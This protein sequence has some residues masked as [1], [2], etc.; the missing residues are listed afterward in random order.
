MG[1]SCRNFTSAFLLA[2]AFVARATADEKADRIDRMYVADVSYGDTLKVSDSRTSTKFMILHLR[3][4]DAPD[5]G[6]SF[7]RESKD[8]LQKL[9]NHKEVDVHWMARD[10][11][12][13]LLADVWLDDVLINQKMIEDGCSWYFAEQSESDELKEAEESAR[14]AKRGLWAEPLPV[15]PWD[16][17]AA[18]S[19][20]AA[21]VS[22]TPKA[23]IAKKVE[24]PKQEATEPEEKPSAA[25]KTESRP[26]YVWVN[27]YTR[28][29]KSGKTSHVK[30]HWRKK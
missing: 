12:G 15:A 22:K 13:R 26:G 9:V 8:A 16:F 23:E 29:S 6:Q 30:G 11:A 3:G 20:K 24:E 14:E 5:K 10:R 4:T 18:H 25:T 7:S 27:G 17:R 21:A 1:A 19:T 28:T 2:F